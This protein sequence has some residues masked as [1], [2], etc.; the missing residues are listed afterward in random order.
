MPGTCAGLRV[1][2][3]TQGRAGPIATMILADYGAEVIRVEPS[4]RDPA[5]DDP[6]YL[7]LNRGK[8]SIDL[9]LA[10][11]EGQGELGRLVAASDVV[12]ESMGAGK[13][14]AAGIG[15]QAALRP[16]PR[17]GVLLAHRL[18][19]VGALCRRSPQ[20]MHWRWRRPESSKDQDGWY[21]DGKRPVFRAP[22]DASYFSRHAGGS[23]RFSAPCGPVTSPV[24]DS[25]SRPTFFMP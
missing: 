5:W 8:K 9:D 7:L 4:E 10:T 15:Y 11:A 14:D 21:Q 19:E 17:P 3:F 22:K 23:G 18:R 20:T 25:W 16:Q 13:A 1:L 24:S 2:D 12:I 6:T